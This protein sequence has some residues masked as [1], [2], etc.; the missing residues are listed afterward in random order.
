MRRQE[1]PG[2]DLASPGS[3]SAPSTSGR[4]SRYV[5]A[6]VARRVLAASGGLCEFPGC[7]RL[8]TV[9]HHVR[10]FGLDP[11]HDSEGIRLL[12]P[13][14]HDLAHTGLVANEDA[15][16]REWRLRPLGEFPAEGARERIDERLWAERSLTR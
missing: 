7:R 15:P 10:R 9:R 4:P 1:N 16:T 12:C 2:R 5:P 11:R 6:A 3:R 13:S 8:G 14:H